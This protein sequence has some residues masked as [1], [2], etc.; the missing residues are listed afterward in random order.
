V[1]ICG[2]KW[3]KFMPGFS[4]KFYYSLDEK[5]R[6]MIPAPF[7]EVLSGHYGE[8]L[9]L[10]NAPF[11]KCLQLYPAEEWQRLLE[12]VRTLP[13]SYEEVRYFMRRVIAS[14]TECELDKQ[15]RLLIP[16][17]YRQDAGI[18]GEVVIVGMVEKIEIWSRD[19]WDRVVDPSR[20][21]IETAINRLAGLGL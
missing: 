5:G 19:E 6:V 15:G 8:G 20:I 17:S 3:N 16:V 13:K 14:A 10:T 2:I 4:G 21:N 12:K 9:Y 11:D 18:D 7:R 1:V